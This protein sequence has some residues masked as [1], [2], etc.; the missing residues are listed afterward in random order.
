[1]AITKQNLDFH[2]KR[3]ENLRENRTNWDSTWQELSDYLCPGRISVN[4]T[5]SK[6]SKTKLLYDHTGA[7]AAQRLAAGLYSRTVNPA[8]KWF[9]LNPDELDEDL[10][11]IPQ[12]A[13][14]LDQARNISQICLNERAAGTYYQIYLDLVTLSSGVLFI[15]EVPLQKP[16]YITYPID[17]VDIVEDYTGNVDTVYRKFKL[18]LRQ[19]GQEFPETIDQVVNYGT[20]LEK[21]PDKVYDVIHAVFPRTD[22]DLEKFDNLNMPI[23]SIYFIPDEKLLLRESG[24][25]EMPYSIPR[26]EVLTG[27]KYGR[28]PGNIALP[29]V[30][31]LNELQ[32]IRLDNAHLRN[33]PPL[34]VPLNA[35]VNPLHLI[36]G[37][38]NINQDET[39]KKASAMH[40]AGDLS[41]QT[42]D[43]KESRGIIKE[44]FYNDQLY[45]RE[46]PQMTATEVRE[47]MDLQMQLM[48]PWQGRLEPEL[49]KPSVLRTLAILLRQGFI[50]P[51]PEELIEME[52][53]P[54]RNQY[55]PSG[56]TK[57]IK[58]TYDSP[59]ARAQ[60]YADIHVIDN[61]KR[62]LAE[63][64]TV[65]PEQAAEVAS[66]FK[67]G[68]MEV[69][70]ARSLGLPNKYIKTE[71]ELAR[72]QEA[73]QQAIAE[74]KAL[75]MASEG[76]KA[77][78]NLKDVPGSEK[79]TK[80]AMDG[81]A[82]MMN[83]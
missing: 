3:Q 33:R 43:I 67:L 76:S 40:M 81:L 79:V 82:Q 50:P 32:K 41:Y 45:L 66:R 5:R 65:N 26:L 77:M 63:I 73:K 37:Y 75:M 13:S 35:Y 14:W 1:M 69:D 31:S 51:P 56:A 38:R 16:R 74:Q 7:L 15:D 72:E 57:N 59:L 28:G 9:F 39:G 8:S 80:G 62:S 6:G 17:Q 20:L 58:V 12:V 54:I 2:T 19:L 49:F 60:R 10:L 42:A 47:R 4:Y 61:T 71:D 18:T 27:E 44:I 36:P 24:Y 34:D 48:G 25:P 30:K 68:E 11:K 64:A 21:E 46:G 78:K 29:E 55:R 53:D 70:R 22:M 23:A 52:F 83:Q